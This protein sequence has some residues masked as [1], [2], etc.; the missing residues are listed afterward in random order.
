MIT[1]RETSDYR[2]CNMCHKW[3]NNFGDW[4]VNDTFFEKNHVIG[5][6]YRPH[7]VCP[8][9]GSIDRSRWIWYI[10]RHKTDVLLSK[11]RILHIAPEY[12]LS[13]NLMEQKQKDAVYICGDLDTH[14]KAYT[15]IQQ[16][17]VTD[18][19]RFEDGFFDYVIMNHV[20]EHVKDER[21]AL[22]EIRRCLAQ[23]GMLIISFPICPEMKTQE[24]PNVTTDADKLKL[25]GQTD[26][27]RLYGSDAH[28]HLQAYGFHVKSLVCR[29]TLPR[30]LRNVMGLIAEDT[31]FLCSPS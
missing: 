5:G 6:G 28:A 15:E 30:I 13:K 7:V 8:S 27:V 25:Y 1:N 10:I 23:N 26:H 24:Y 9:C 11:G 16:I 21:A 18:L 2:Y 3:S 17:D 20:L 22:R 14:Y 19:S 29:Q 12:Q 31:A 4:G